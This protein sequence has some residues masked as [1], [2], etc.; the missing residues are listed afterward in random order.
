MS[1]TLLSAIETRDD[2]LT[3]IENATYCFF[4]LA[5]LLLVLGVPGD[6]LIL[7]DV[8]VLTV[9][10]LCLRRFSSRIAAVILLAETLRWVIIFARS[11]GILMFLSGVSL[12]LAALA[13]WASFKLH[14]RFATRVLER[15]A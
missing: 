8:I 4:W 5:G 10:A 2:A 7:S 13:I 14:G 11:D 1:T 9:S 12:G 6:P 3:I 15:A